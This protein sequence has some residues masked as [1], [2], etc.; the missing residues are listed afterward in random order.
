MTLAFYHAK[1][2]RRDEAEADMREAESRGATSL[3]AQFTKAQT[4]AVLG[5][6]DEA[7]RI[8]LRCLDGGL[9]PVQVDYAMDL[10]EIRNDPRY[11]KRV[12]ELKSPPAKAG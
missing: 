10:Q 5:K 4:L 9:S 8:V 11:R 6:R 7:L 2:G 1:T 3:D 12:A